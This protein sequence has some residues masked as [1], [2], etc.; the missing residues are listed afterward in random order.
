MGQ[1]PLNPAIKL[2]FGFQ[3]EWGKF[4]TRNRAFLEAF[5]RLQ[6]T[7]ELACSR[8][9]QLTEPIDK[10]VLMFG[11]VC[12]EDFFEITLCCGNGSGHAAQKL[13]RGLYERAVTLRYLHEHPT[14]IEDFLDFY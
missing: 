14:E 2:I 13:L 5:P 6:K 4:E 3:E 1:D 7:L 8:N 9:A 11:R 12:V 10:F